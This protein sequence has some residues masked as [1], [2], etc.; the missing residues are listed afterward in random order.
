MPTLHGPAWQAEVLYT[1]CWIGFFGN[2]FIVGHVCLYTY[3]I[4]I[5]IPRDSLRHLRRFF[6]IAAELVFSFFYPPI[7]GG[8]RRA[9]EI[10]G[11]AAEIPTKQT[12]LRRFCFGCGMRREF[13]PQCVAQK[14][15]PQEVLG[16]YTC[17]YLFV[18]QH[19]DSWLISGGLARWTV[20]Y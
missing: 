18:N 5:Y 19:A 9:A 4:Y 1:R 14:F 10:G 20:K 11:N 6:R 2:R 13:P 12:V 3:C 8:N 15:P 16:I 7:C 17:T